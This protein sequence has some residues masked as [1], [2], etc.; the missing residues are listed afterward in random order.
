MLKEGIETLPG[1]TNP[2]LL[3]IAPHG[4]PDDDENTGGLVRSVQKILDCSAIINEVYRRPKL[5]KETPKKVYEKHSLEKRILNLNYKP[6]AEKLAYYI[7]QI[8]QSVKE[9]DSTIVLWI[10]GID[11]KNIKD[12]SK[13]LGLKERLHCL[14]GY[15]Q[16]GNDTCS[17]E[18]KDILLQALNAT[19]IKSAHTRD[20]ALNYKGHDDSN[21]NRWFKVGGKGLEAVQS[22][23]L[24]LGYAGV[25]DPN[26]V[27][28]TAKKLAHALLSLKSALKTDAAEKAEDPALVVGSLNL[29]S[30]YCNDEHHG[31]MSQFGEFI[32]DVFYGRDPQRVLQKKPVLKESLFSLITKLKEGGSNVPSKSWFYNAR[33]LA[34]HE[35]V[36]KKRGFQIFGNLG[37]SHKL[38]LLPFRDLEKIEAL[39]TEATK[40]GYNFQALKT[41]IKE[42]KGSSR[43]NLDK[44]PTKA[45]LAMLDRMARLQLQKKAEGKIEHHQE[46]LVHFQK[47]LERI[48]GVL[49]KAEPVIGGKNPNKDLQN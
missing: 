40:R 24:E 20:D 16:P 45:E 6:Q 13:A 37:H 3:L 44:V 29:L 32:I 41:R 15:G 43:L 36:F 2:N 1:N 18:L 30:G 19:G 33:D 7:A 47:C 10:H 4:Y 11:D 48:N 38:A 17:L 49:E 8:R 22:I 46:R 35:Q 14:I 31:A 25:R 21:M 5:L 27:E 23:Q 26:S 42:E 28:G 34:A 39:A 9:P 12:E